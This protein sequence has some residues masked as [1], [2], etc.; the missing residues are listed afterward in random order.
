MNKRYEQDK[1]LLRKFLKNQYLY[2]HMKIIL[3]NFNL[4]PDQRKTR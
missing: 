2:N 3:H 1:K 4:A